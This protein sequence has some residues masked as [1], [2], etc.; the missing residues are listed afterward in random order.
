VSQYR[1]GEGKVENGRKLG[2]VCG[3]QDG[4]TS[5]PSTPHS[6]SVCSEVGSLHFRQDLPG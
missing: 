2:L 6:I 1:A 4:A 5:V 3:G